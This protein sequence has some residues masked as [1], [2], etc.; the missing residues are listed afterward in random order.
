MLSLSSHLETLETLQSRKESN[1]PIFHFHRFLRKKFWNYSSPSNLRSLHLVAEKIG[2]S[3]FILLKTFKAFI[4]SVQIKEFSSCRL[5][6]SSNRLQPSS[7]SN[8][9]QI[10]FRLAQRRASLRD[11]LLCA[12]EFY[13]LVNFILNT[14]ILLN[15]CNIQEQ[16]LIL[17]KYHGLFYFV[18]WTINILVFCYI[19]ENQP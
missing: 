18:T 10:L 13:L 12:F 16:P 4:H 3:S 9:L 8:Q 2:A 5:S 17:W 7:S 14:I 19:Y 15:C 1:F 11:F 6:S